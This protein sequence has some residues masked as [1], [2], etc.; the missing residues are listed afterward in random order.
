MPKIISNRQIVDDDWRLLD[1]EALLSPG[2][3]G[4]VPEIPAGDV[5]APLRLLRLRRDE[6]SAR[7]GRLGVLLAGDDEPEA[8]APEVVCG[9]THP[10]LRPRG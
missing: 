1:A 9:P 6:L 5:I 3:D 8:V 7:P 2:E 4:F 10:P